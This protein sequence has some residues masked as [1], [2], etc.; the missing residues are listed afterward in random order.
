MPTI[1]YPLPAPFLWG[2]HSQQYKDI[3]LL[4]N[5]DFEKFQVRVN[6]DRVRKIR[7]KNGTDRDGADPARLHGDDPAKIQCPMEKETIVRFLHQM[8]LF[9]TLLPL[10]NYWI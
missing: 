8:F 3:E 1:P 5:F 9:S 10:F 4:I 6:M 7:N 2:C